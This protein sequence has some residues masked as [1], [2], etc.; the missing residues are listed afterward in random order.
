[1]EELGREGR[2]RLGKC[3]SKT[4]FSLDLFRDECSSSIKILSLLDSY[5]AG[6]GVVE[7]ASTFC[8]FQC[9]KLALR[10]P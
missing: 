2:G 8:A 1:M 6:V 5:D 3:E 4:I 7:L 9:S 10:L